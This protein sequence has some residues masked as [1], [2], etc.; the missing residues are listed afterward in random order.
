MNKKNNSHIFS[1][2]PILF[3]Q[4]VSYISFALVLAASVGAFFSARSWVT[5]GKYLQS[6]DGEQIEVLRLIPFLKEL[7]QQTN[8]PIALDPAFFANFKKAEIFLKSATA[9]L[10][11][12]SEL[13]PNSAATVSTKGISE[14]T[15]LKSLSGGAAAPAMKN[16]STTKEAESS[17]TLLPLSDNPVIA[18]FQRLDSKVMSVVFGK[19]EKYAVKSDKKNDDEKSELTEPAEKLKKN[20][21]PSTPLEVLVSAKN[22]EQAIGVILA[23][24]KGLNDLAVLARSGEVLI[25]PKGPLE[26]DKLP[27]ESAVKKYAESIG[28]F[29]KAHNAWQKNATDI[30][31]TLDLQKALGAV[32]EQKVLLEIDIGK[33]TAGKSNLKLTDVPPKVPQS[34]W[35]SKLPQES[36]AVLNT[37]LLNM[38]AIKE[39]ANDYGSLRL[40]AQKKSQSIQYFDFKGAGG[41][42]GLIL[43]SVI[44]TFG[45]ILGAYM[46]LGNTRRNAQD[47]QRASK[48]TKAAGKLLSSIDLGFASAS[49][50]KTTKGNSQTSDSDQSVDQLN[51][52][53]VM[54]VISELSDDLKNKINK[55]DTHFKVLAQLNTKLRHSIDT[56][57]EKSGQIRTNASDKSSNSPYSQEMG[58]N[59]GGPLDQLQ[60]AF[61]ALK[62][63]G[64]RLYLAILDNH[65][66]KQLAVETEQ[67]NLLVERV[68][69]TVSK[70]R[71]TLATALEQATPVEEQAPKISLEAIE[72]LSMDAK[73]VM[74]DLQLWQGEFDGL[75]KSFAELKREARI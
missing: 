66:S 31:T 68:E 43:V 34:P 70:M 42:L 35:Y 59:R 3:W 1:Q 41:F 64:V 67:L 9:D 44:T 72:L 28:N 33:K 51:V 37:Y 46:A 15:A 14:P 36:A 52:K 49:N 40:A 73:Q 6:I 17:T 21:K 24:E 20:P 48:Q 58:I 27:S 74:R 65:S 50:V 55:I 29:A 12:Q 4:W 47:L 2:R 5:E 23:Q 63:Q 62:Q 13:S 53:T 26:L 57:H 45:I 54:N 61:S 71:S 56:L 8:G 11:N 30:A 75:N 69:A 22:T 60:D 7:Q 19:P 39:F 10:K 25:G 16:S 38:R 32:L 18:L